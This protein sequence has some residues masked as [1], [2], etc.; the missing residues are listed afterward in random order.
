MAKTPENDAAEALK[1]Q[2]ELTG[3]GFSTVKDGKV[4]LITKDML[5]RLLA[6]CEKSGQ[7]RVVV[8]IQDPPAVGER[9]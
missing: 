4:M 3:F 1:M 7:D 5:E 8:F 9:S 6:R 2:A